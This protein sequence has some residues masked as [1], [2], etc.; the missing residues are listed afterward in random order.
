M[1]IIYNEKGTSYWG[2]LNPTPPLKTSSAGYFSEVAKAAPGKFVAIIYAL[3]PGGKTDLAVESNGVPVAINEGSTTSP[4]PP[5]PT[6]TSG[7]L[8]LIDLPTYRGL[9]MLAQ[10]AV[11]IAARE[12]RA[13]AFWPR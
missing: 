12:V 4:A 10:D 3:Y 6:P 1:D 11:E 7:R 13:L 2:N 8:P 9:G 5:P